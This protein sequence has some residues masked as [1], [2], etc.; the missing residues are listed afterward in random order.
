MVEA[1]SPTAPDSAVFAL[2]DVAERASNALARSVASASGRVNNSICLLDRMS[3]G[4]KKALII[5]TN[6]NPLNCY[7]YII[8]L[9]YQQKHYITLEYYL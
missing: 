1:E 7:Y 9:M 5:Q 8:K 2:A 3:Y 4:Y 6:T